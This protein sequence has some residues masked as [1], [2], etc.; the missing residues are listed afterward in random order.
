ML[1]FVWNRCGA[2]TAVGH[3][4]RKRIYCPKELTVLRTQAQALLLTPFGGVDP[5]W[6][7]TQVDD[8]TIA[9]LVL[10]KRR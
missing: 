5:T 7:G 10:E 6:H 8:H 9:S 3:E 2:D 4:T 1:T